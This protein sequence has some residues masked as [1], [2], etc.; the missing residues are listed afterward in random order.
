MSWIYLL[1]AGLGEVGFVIFMKLSDGFTRTKYSILCG[2]SGFA[3]F[4]LL[5]KA[6]L[7]LPIGTAYGVW[8]G[9]GAAG[10]VLLG[11]LFFGEPR[12][13]RR[14][15]FIAMIII[16]VIGLKAVS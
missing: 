2:I 11:M 16:S 13:W 1:F 6:L 14:I 7:E 4:Y 12:N 3:S 10:S 8:T 15:L 5:S 9:I